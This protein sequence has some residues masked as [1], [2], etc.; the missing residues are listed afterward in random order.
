VLGGWLTGSEIVE[1]VRKGLITIQPFNEEQVNPNSYNYRL[2]TRLHR[3]TST[4]LDMLSEDEFEDF[5]IG[6][7]GVVLEPG[8]CYLG[9]TLETFGSC[10]Y[11]SLITGRSSV[12]RKFVTNHV[13]AGLI[14]VGFLGE[15]TLEITVQ[16]RTRVYAGLPFGQIFWFSLHGSP[17]PLYN[18]KYQR[19]VGPTASRLSRDNRHEVNRG[20]SESF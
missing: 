5:D 7:S 14:D 20:V 3:L 19:Q 12:G 15:I 1:C 16:K 10:N 2:G 18:G 17:D 9:H 13:T 8:E 11:A 6:S 4:E